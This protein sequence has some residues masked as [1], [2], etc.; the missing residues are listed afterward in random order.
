MKKIGLIGG[1]TWVSTIDYYRY[2]NEYVNKELG[3]INFAECIIYSFN[4]ADIKKNNDANDWDKT[5]DMM[6]TAA[7]H[8]KNAGAEL[9]LLGANT[10]HL[11]AE[12]LEERVDLP[13]IHIAKVTADDITRHGLKKVALLGTRFV[14][15]LDFFTSKLAAQGIEA[16][17]PGED[18]RQFIQDTI[19]YEL[20]K[21]I[22]T[23]A[24]RQRYLSIIEGL[25]RDGAEGIILGCTEIPLIIKQ[26][27]VSVKIFDTVQLHVAAAVKVALG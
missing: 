20:S 19:Y 3:G 15:E 1:T 16:I 21:N 8:L 2:L 27:D 17:I 22:L 10:M 13:L 18:D 7:L 23:D 4:F 6:T 14:M 5:L 26:Q 24:T 9:L 25:I 12:R 11:I